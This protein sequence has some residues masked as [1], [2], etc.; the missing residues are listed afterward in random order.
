MNEHDHFESLFAPELA[1]TEITD[2]AV[3]WKILLVDDEADIHSVLRLALQN[4]SM[5]GRP[6]QLLDAYSAAE[7]KILFAEHPDTALILLDV[8]METEQ[9]GLH[10]VDY[11]RHDLNNRNVQIMVIT[12]QPGYAPQ[13]DVVVRYE[14]DDYRLK[15][16]L[17]ADK[18][19]TAVYASLRA[20]KTLTELEAQHS[21][22]AMQTR[23][24]AR[25][26]HIFEHAEWGMFVSNFDGK[27]IEL[28]NPAFARQRGFTVDEVLQM[29]PDQLFTPEERGK[30]PDY[31]RKAH[32]L[33]HIIFESLHLRK[34]SSTFPVLADAT[35]VKDAQGRMLYQVI[36]VQDITERKKAEE[37][38]H[39]LD[40]LTWRLQKNQ[41][42]DR[43]AGGI[44]HHFNNHLGA[45]IG[46]LE[47]AIEDLPKQTET[48]RRLTRAMES[49]LKSTEVSGQLLSYLGQVTGENAE[50]KLSD[51]CRRILLLL[52]AAMPK[53]VILKE[54][55]PT[56]GPTI[57]AKADQ[58]EQVVANLVNNAFEA[59]G[60]KQG[61][62]HLKIKTV[63][64]ADI[65]TSHLFPLN[66][67]P[68]DN[69]HAC[70]EVTDTG[71][72]IAN[73]AID[74]LFDPFYSTKFPGRGLGLSTALGI[75]TAHGGA[76][77]VASKIGR[78]ST[79]RVFLPISAEDTSPKPMQ[80]PVQ[81]SANVGGAMVLLVE[82][83]EIM[84]DMAQAML[85]RLGFR[86]ITAT[87]GI[88]A[89]EVF[90]NHSDTI[91]VV[92]C[93]LSMPRM[94]GWQ[95][96]A[97]LRLIRPALPVVLTSGHDEAT[98]RDGALFEGSQVILHK[99]YQKSA[100][101]EALEKALAM[102]FSSN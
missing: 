90:K 44:A 71:C 11:I 38:K 7:T 22:L 23:D 15:S 82:G 45:V 51:I 50:H 66:W 65:S 35:V 10:L 26:A 55:L 37:E 20:F 98:I 69:N 28:C 102:T 73:E 31:L 46:N 3:P 61:T 18:L 43:M 75:V 49:V 81:V 91:D 64:P 2:L 14:I 86:V 74:K 57:K 41:S 97:A 29:R 93:A 12:G 68:E 48:A 77:A 53:N 5:E 33:G 89:V 9:A 94:N 88:E 70:I 27:R 40:K 84:C 62:T 32:D 95:T 1:Q 79:F 78:G 54:D 85:T 6:V 42:L 76:F 25:W 58:I 16:D 36:N 67:Q 24:L 99:P 60:D 56:P 59:I 101:K 47:M 92:L 21:L 87:D 34:D 96:L 39:K 30:L 17:N 100:L 80:Q 19:F 52:Q 72:G 83:E 63:S 13:R 4:I 8:V